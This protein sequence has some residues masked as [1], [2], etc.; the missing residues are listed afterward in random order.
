MQFSLKLNFTIKGQVILVF[1]YYGNIGNK[2]NLLR[3]LTVNE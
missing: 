2:V 3:W 1:S